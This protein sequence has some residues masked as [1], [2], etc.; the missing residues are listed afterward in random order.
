MKVFWA[1]LYKNDFII[2]GKSRKK[3]DKKKTKTKSIKHFHIKQK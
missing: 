2:S 3:I 1:K